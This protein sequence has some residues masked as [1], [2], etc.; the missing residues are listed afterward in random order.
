MK[1]KT[2]PNP[3]LALLAALIAH[4]SYLQAPD[5]TDRVLLTVWYAGAVLGVGY[6]LWFI[7]FLDKG[8]F[9]HPVAHLIS[10]GSAMLGQVL[11]LVGAGYSTNV[12]PTVLKLGGVLPL[13]WSCTVI[14]LLLEQVKQLAQRETSRRRPRGL[15]LALGGLLVLTVVQFIFDL[16][17]QHQG[18][19]DF[20][21]WALTACLALGLFE[22]VRRWSRLL[23]SVKVKRE[24]TEEDEPA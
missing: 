20:I 6:F 17:G 16:N 15:G 12:E 1:S 13:G 4:V 24:D 10:Q 3:V 8:R 22:L 23:Q 2:P 7:I 11:I 14:V 9:G 5:A 19:G 18:N 21:K